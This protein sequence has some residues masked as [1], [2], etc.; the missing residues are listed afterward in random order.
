MTDQEY[1]Q[2]QEQ[3]LLMAYIIKNLDLDGFLKRIATAETLG[4]IIDPTLYLKAGTG[5]SEIKQI[6]LAM[7]QVEKAVDTCKDLGF[8]AG[9]VEHAEDN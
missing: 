5:L 4:P 9:K 8:V 2:T 3:I 7:Q 1:P 6:A